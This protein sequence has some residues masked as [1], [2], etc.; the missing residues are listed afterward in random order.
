MRNVL[1]IMLIS[2]GLI[3]GGVVSA[4]TPTP[5]PVTTPTPTM[6]DQVRENVIILSQI[7][8]K[9]ITMRILCRIYIRNIHGDIELT[10]GQKSAL[11]SQY[12]TLKSETATLYQNLL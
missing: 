3:L 2:A 8:E 7:K 1:V 12:Q 9:I 10:A 5:S 6:L 11:L 4:Q